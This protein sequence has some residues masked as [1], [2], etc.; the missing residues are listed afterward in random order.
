MTVVAFE[1]VMVTAL[2]AIWVQM[3]R[4]TEID[5]VAVPWTVPAQSMKMKREPRIPFSSRA[6]QI[7]DEAREMADDSGLI[8]PSAIW[9]PLSASTASKLVPERG[10]F[11]VVHRFR[12][13]FPNCRELE[14]S[15]DWKWPKAPAVL[16]T[17]SPQAEQ[18]FTAQHLVRPRLI[19]WI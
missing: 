15:E 18:G 16:E 6:L 12:S 7:L 11:V 9:R 3:V 10:I 5:L 4:W 14:F 1:L 17:S 8:F 19:Q 2:Q 13:G